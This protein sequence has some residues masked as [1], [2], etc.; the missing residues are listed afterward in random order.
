MDQDVKKKLLRKVP[1]GLFVLAA[2]DGNEVAAA[3]VSW[4]SQ[5]SFEPPLV[6]VALRNDGHIRQVVDKTRQ[7]AVSLVGDHQKDVA[8]AFFRPSKVDEAGI[9]GYAIESGQ[10]TGAPL[11]T[12]APGWFE[13]RVA[14]T[15]KRGDHTVYIAE[16]ISCGLR[17]PEVGILELTDTDWTYGG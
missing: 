5:V 3:T 13:A 7:F 4:I 15:V 9:N 2:K 17:A 14:D 8:S 10:E 16:V 11:L 6:M 12:V 1:Y